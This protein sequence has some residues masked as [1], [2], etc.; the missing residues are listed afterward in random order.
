MLK[1]LC[2]LA[3]ASVTM[4]VAA[5]GASASFGFANG[6]NMHGGGASG[7]LT[8]WDS[9]AGIARAADGSF[10]VA[11][12]NDNRVVKLD[13]NGHFVAEWGSSGTA[14]GQFRNPS[15][16]GIGPVDGQVYVVDQTNHRV[17][18]FSQTG[19]Y[20]RGWGSSGTGDG[21]FQYPSGIAFDA[22]GTVFVSD[23]NNHRVEYFDANGNFLGKIA[24]ASG[25]GQ[26]ATPEGLAIGSDGR[27]FVA[28]RG[29]VAPSSHGRVAVYASISD[30]SPHQYLGSIGSYGDNPGQFIDPHGVFLKPGTPDEI[31]VTN[32]W[33][34]HRVQ[35]F[36]TD[37]S[38]ATPYLSRWGY[39]IGF[40]DGGV[41]NGG[42][43][44]G[45]DP[46][47][48]S[49]PTQV[50]LDS[51]NNAWVTSAGNHRIDVFSNAD[52][53]DPNAATYV[54]SWGTDGSGPGQFVNPSGVAAAPDGTAYVAESY[55]GSYARIQHVT[56]KG[57]VLDTFGTYGSGD[58][59]ISDVNGMSVGPG[60]DL[61][62][63]DSGNNRVQ[64]FSSTGEF[65]SK[66]TAVS[67]TP[68]S[69]PSDVVVAS[70]GTLYIADF[71]NRR[72][73]VVSG[74]G[75]TESAWGSQGYTDDAAEFQGLAGLA[76]SPD[77]QHVYVLDSWANHVK[78]F[79]T[80]GVFEAK[81][82]PYS[83]L[84]GTGDQEF[85]NPYG[86][87]VD[88]ATGVV[89]VS[90]SSNDRLKRLDPSL[91]FVSHSGGHGRGDGQFQ[92]PNAV[93][94]DQQGYAWVADRD[95]DRVQRLGGAPQVQISQPAPG[96]TVAAG[97]ALPVNYSVTDAGASCDTVDG[98]STGPLAAGAN[99]I[100]VT[101]S[102]GQGSGSASVLVNATAPA[103]PAGGGATVADPTLKLPKR[104]RLAKKLKFSVICPDGC[105]V[106][107]K[108][109][110]GRQ[111]S[112]IK[113]FRVAAK[114]AAQVVTVKL[115][116]AQT[117]K[118]KSWMVNN[119]TVYLSVTVVS[120]KATQGKTGRAKIA[121]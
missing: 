5:T 27:I 76:L 89:A 87:D 96:T 20:L 56:A 110:F 108:L 43:G 44:Y 79:S 33:N 111:G 84:G 14:A 24:D 52:G 118:A 34:A 114:P 68:L 40:A 41:T 25:G 91:A 21:Q 8:Q 63:A 31:Y 42:P 104:L 92:S 1:S 121:K 75:L 53:N 4:L 102:N 57:A 101:C 3:A 72:I 32:V 78:K 69:S 46:G 29:Y 35:R 48:L 103:P 16:I 67:G 117:R 54:T 37:L 80:A 39:D 93:S 115:S 9:L 47:A 99:T 86:I 74:D 23:G 17:Q 15:A 51:A 106:T 95:N 2:A 73:A 65:K 82:G 81:S 45:S 58:G 88:P 97:T 66:I 26:L 19:T 49:T 61:W 10:F 36:T 116:G 71:G 77:D 59:Q 13:S 112:R 109:L 120:Y 119:K 6:L 105:T 12:L 90:D 50:I 7:E 83:G 18:V 11:D 107:P 60:G 70:D 62:V 85:K 100:T 22:T 64:R 28:D 30:P 38:D 55:G 98:A 94:F 113:Q